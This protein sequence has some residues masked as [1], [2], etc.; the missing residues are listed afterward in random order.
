MKAWMS[1]WTKSGLDEEGGIQED[2]KVADLAEGVKMEPSMFR[3]N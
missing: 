1:V 3:E 2:T